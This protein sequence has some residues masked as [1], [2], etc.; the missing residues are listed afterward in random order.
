MKRPQITQDIIDKNYK[1]ADDVIADANTSLAL[2]KAS[3]RA[4]KEIMELIESKYGLGLA[5]VARQHERAIASIVERP[6]AC[7]SARSRYGSLASPDTDTHGT[8]ASPGTRRL[9]FDA[10]LQ[11][12]SGTISTTGLPS[13]SAIT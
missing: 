11:V 3:E 12:P 6:C 9:T 7:A 1:S 10:C 13:N 4:A 8:S 5:A 2:V